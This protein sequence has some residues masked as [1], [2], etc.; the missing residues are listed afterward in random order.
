MIGIAIAQSI[1]A[2]RKALQLGKYSIF[3]KARRYH[4]TI[5]TSVFL[6]IL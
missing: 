4:Y 6:E 5:I 1:A 3:A 2:I